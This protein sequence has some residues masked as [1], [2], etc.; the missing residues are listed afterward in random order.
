MTNNNGIVV[1]VFGSLPPDLTGP[2]FFPDFPPCVNLPPHSPDSIVCLSVVPKLAKASRGRK[3]KSPG[4]LADGG[5]APVKRGASQ[6]PSPA[7][8]KTSRIESDTMPFRNGII[9]I[10]K[11][12]TSAT[13]TPGFPLSVVTPPGGAAHQTPRT[14]LSTDSKIQTTS[15]EST[16]PSDPG[17]RTSSATPSGS[18][19]TGNPAS[20]LFVN[21]SSSSLL[22]QAGL[23][24]HQLAT[25]QQ[26]GVDPFR[27]LHNPQ[28]AAS[29]SAAAAAGNPFFSS[30][31]SATIPLLHMLQQ[32]QQQQQQQQVR[33]VV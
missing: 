27:L 6:T 9:G 28:L 5:T 11:S 17:H 23:L 4:V 31:N 8:L 20:T 3:M 2:S 12:D 19:G 29:L 13:C 7:P 14:P 24:S 10:A 26:L 30:N 33:V 16:H 21:T 25:S 32:Q 22:T 1:F 15:A 18:G